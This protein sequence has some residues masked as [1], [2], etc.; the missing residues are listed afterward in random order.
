MTGHKAIWAIHVE[1]RFSLIDD[2]QSSANPVA[3]VARNVRRAIE[4]T[5]CVTLTRLLSIISV[6]RG[7]LIVQNFFQRGLRGRHNC[8]VFDAI[9]AAKRTRLVFNCPHF[10]IFLGYLVDVKRHFN[11]FS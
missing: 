10:I 1:R 5:R 2:C 9:V 6:G 11:N 3:Y 7:G 8:C 4:T